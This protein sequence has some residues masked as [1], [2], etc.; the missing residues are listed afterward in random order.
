MLDAVEQQAIRNGDAGSSPDYFAKSGTNLAGSGRTFAPCLLCLATRCSTGTIIWLSPRPRGVISTV[1]EPA[2]LATNSTE[3]DR[4]LYAP[5][6]QTIDAADDNT[7][8]LYR[9]AEQ[10]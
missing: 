9:P 4:V 7:A 3:A 1:G 2:L 6:D 8:V 5:Q 10:G